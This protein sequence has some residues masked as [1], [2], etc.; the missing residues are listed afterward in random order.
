MISGV[1]SKKRKRSR[2]IGTVR[3][4]TRFQFTKAKLP[5]VP[6]FYNSLFFIPFLLFI[7]LCLIFLFYVPIIDTNVPLIYSNLWVIIYAISYLQPQGL[8]IEQYNFAHKAL[9]IVITLDTY[10]GFL[11]KPTKTLFLIAYSH[12]RTTT[13]SLFLSWVY[14]HQVAS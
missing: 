10:S 4:L 7:L 6:F 3:F 1:R 5:L 14:F 2:N 8:R 13:L 12:R 11:L 9:I